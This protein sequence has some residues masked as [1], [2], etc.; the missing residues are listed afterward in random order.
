MPPSCWHASSPRQRGAHHRS[1]AEKH[2][3]RA[4]ALRRHSPMAL[5]SSPA[6][7]QMSEIPIETWVYTGQMVGQSFG[8]FDSVRH[9][10]SNAIEQRGISDAVKTGRTI[11]YRDRP[12][13]NHGC[14]GLALSCRTLP[15]IHDGVYHLGRCTSHPLEYTTRVIIYFKS[16]HN[17]PIYHAGCVVYH[18]P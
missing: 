15:S 5:L 12:R 6:T 3:P 13:H 11:Y 2:C 14:N 1:I 7:P 8:P 16:Q 18:T 17:H 4:A 9:G 10:R